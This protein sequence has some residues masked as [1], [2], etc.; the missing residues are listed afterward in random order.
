M[1]ETWSITK[2]KGAC[3]VCEGEF[4][5]NRPFFSCLLQEQAEFVRRDYCADCWGTDLPER[6][7]CFW[8][9]RQ[10]PASETRSVDTGLML[11]FFDRLQR[12]GT[13]QEGSFRFVLALYLM[14]R[15]ELKLREVSRADGA[16]T[17]V[18]ER[19]SSGEKVEVGNPGL[20]EQ[21]IT[22]TA[23]RLSELLDAAL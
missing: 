21:E 23:A 15:K 3:C 16:E 19:R 12:P 1:F 11:E 22:Q 10:A 17:L 13:A 5:P 8:R 6:P 2:S 7:F 4:A 14:R 18:L 20:S 9:S